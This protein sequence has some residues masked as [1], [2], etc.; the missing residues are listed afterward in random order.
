MSSILSDPEAPKR[1]G[2]IGPKAQAKLKRQEQFRIWKHTIRDLFILVG[3]IIALILIGLGITIAAL[4]VIGIIA[5]GLY[6]L[7]IG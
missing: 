1:Q 2:G 6:S 7:V 3:H 4:A 5:W